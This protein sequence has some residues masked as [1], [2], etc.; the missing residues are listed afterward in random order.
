MLPFTVDQFFEVFAVY[1]QA[2]WTVHGAAFV[3]A[4]IVWWA[5][6]TERLW[7]GRAV[8]ILLGVF[9]LWNGLA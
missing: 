8:A 7:G 9:W 5:L 3:L 6:F 4:V 2:I 1:N